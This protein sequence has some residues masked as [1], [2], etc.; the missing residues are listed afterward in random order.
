MKLRRWWFWYAG[1]AI[2]TAA[3]VIGAVVAWLLI[4]HWLG[5]WP[6]VRP[7]RH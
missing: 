1:P 2:A 5:E 3:I 4:M 7:T 6:F